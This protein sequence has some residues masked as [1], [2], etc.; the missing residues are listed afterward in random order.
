M[1]EADNLSRNIQV[2]KELQR[3]AWNHLADPALTTFER[4]ETRNQLKQT[5]AE[6]RSCLEMM[7][8]R[9]RFRPR[10]VQEGVADSLDKFEF[11]LLAGD[12]R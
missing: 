12:Q 2:L 7:S 8:E 1:T 5:G 10:P 11:R 3:A 4:R 6:L 9:M